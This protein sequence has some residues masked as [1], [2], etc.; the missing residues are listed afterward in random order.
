MRF[1]FKSFK[2]VLAKANRYLTI[3]ARMRGAQAG[4]MDRPRARDMGLHQAL[5]VQAGLSRWLGRLRLAF[6]KL[7]GHHEEIKAWQP[8]TVDPLRKPGRPV[9][10]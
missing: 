2:E 8:L 3:G 10:K 6:V 4:S 7:R 5:R 9:T 1:P